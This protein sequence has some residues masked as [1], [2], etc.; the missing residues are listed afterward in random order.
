MNLSFKE[1]NELV[2]CVGV[3]IRK[4]ELINLDVAN[5]LYDRLNSEIE[6]RVKSEDIENDIAWPGKRTFSTYLDAAISAEDT[7][8][9]DL[10]ITVC[11]NGD[12]SYE[13]VDGNLIYIYQKKGLMVTEDETKEITI[14][15]FVNILGAGTDYDL[16]DNEEGSLGQF[17]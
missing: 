9:V 13:D 11:D 7:F 15:E 16:S 17:S 14:Q 6:S 4:G 3:A 8:G 5:E 10:D 2:Y 1:L 12:F